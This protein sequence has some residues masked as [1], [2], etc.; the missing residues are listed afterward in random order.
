MTSLL[1]ALALAAQTSDSVRQARYERILNSAND[2][3]GRLRGVIA[4]FRTDLPSASRELVLERADRVRAMCHGADAA[5]IEV[6]SL[7][8]EGL[9]SRRGE[10]E[11]AQL[12]KGSIEMRRVFAR[13][14]REWETPDPPVAATADSL[15]A[16]GPYRT[17]QLEA[18]VRR[19]AEQLRHFM[20]KTGL[21]TPLPR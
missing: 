15:Q 14:A 12:Q 2:S 1:F 11:Q 13:C 4:V 8:A 20:N 9:Y 16:W 3:L 17:A 19:F 21:K 10:R 5:V 18:A 6:L 7:L